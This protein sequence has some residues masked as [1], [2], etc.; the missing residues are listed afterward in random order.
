MPP[1]GADVPDHEERYYRVDFGPVTLVF[2]DLCNG[3]DETP[4]NDTSAYLNTV[5]GCRAPDFNP[6]TAQYAWL[7]AQLASAQLHSE[8]TF[9]V[10]H[11]VP[12]SV[13]PHGAEDE[14]Q[15]G[16]PARILTPLFLQY[17]VDA[18][19]AGHDEMY[20][21]SAVTGEERRPD[22]SMHPATIHFFDVGIGG[23]GLRGPQ[24]DL[25]NP[26]QEFL[27]HA[28]APEVW[29]GA[30]LVSGGKHYGHLEVQ[31]HTNARGRWEA[32]LTPVIA[33]PTMD[34]EGAV[35]NFERRTYTDV[36]TIEGA[37]SLPPES[38]KATLMEWARKTR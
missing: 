12:Y 13:G 19:F 35:T 11:Q 34:E 5:N 36:V 24:P 8:F 2:L 28:D 6:G 27:A 10:F 16:V 37:S 4:A 9:V 14:A 25:E 22:D 31:V 17:G 23:D 38:P 15:S 3:A 18:V 20:E 30:R 21:R 33:F 7:E 1:N 29:S 26:F 32:I